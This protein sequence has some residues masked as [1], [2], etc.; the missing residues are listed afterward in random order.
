MRILG[1]KNS[2]SCETES[3]KKNLFYRNF[4]KNANC[5]PLL[6]EYESTFI[7]CDIV[8]LKACKTFKELAVVQCTGRPFGTPQGYE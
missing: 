3:Y 7:F 2:D 6:V 8:P 1:S 5:N 4:F